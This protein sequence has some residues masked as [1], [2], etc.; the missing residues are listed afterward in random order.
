MKMAQSRRQAYSVWKLHLRS[1]AMHIN[2]T[3]EKALASAPPEIRVQA[4]ANYH[5]EQQSITK[6]LSETIFKKDATAWRQWRRFC[7]WLQIAPE[8]KDNK[9]YIPFLQSFA[10]IVAV[11]HFHLQGR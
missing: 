6:G 3:T 2:I 5:A 7:I 11:N 9:D 1:L 10:G 8:R 4:A